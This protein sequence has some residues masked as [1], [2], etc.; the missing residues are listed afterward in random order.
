MS[1]EMEA[2]TGLV[3]GTMAGILLLMFIGL[4]VWVYGSR[5]RTMFETAARLPLEEDRSGADRP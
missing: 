4:W 1:H 3:R 2:L 5:R